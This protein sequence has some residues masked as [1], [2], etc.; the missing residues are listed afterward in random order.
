MT[1]RIAGLDSVRWLG[2]TLVVMSH[3]GVL[4]QGG[5]GNRLLSFLGRISFVIYI[6]HWYFIP[7][8][9]QQTPVK[10]FLLLYF[11]TIGVAIIVHAVVEKPAIIFTKRYKISD[12]LTYYRNG[13]IL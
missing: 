9:N 1:E 2:I 6:F 11:V 8:L 4:F 5:L 7:V 10:N 3:C 12:V 13:V